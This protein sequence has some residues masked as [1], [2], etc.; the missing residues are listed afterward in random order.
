MA[1]TH[2]QGSSPVSTDRGE[3]LASTLWQR[4]DDSAPIAYQSVDGQWEPVPWAEL[5]SRVERLAAGLIASGV[6]KRDRVALMS[7]TRLEWTV[8]DLAVVSIGAVT[9]PIYPTDSE[10]QCAHVLEN[11]GARWAIAETGEHAARLESARRDASDLREVV[12]IDEGGLEALAQRGSDDD[13]VAVARRVDEL[14]PDD[15]ATI[16]YT[17]GTTGPPKGCALT[18]GN[19]N[20]TA[21]QAETALER[22]FAGDASTLLFLPLAHIFTRLIQFGCLHQ[23]V[24]VGY[25][26]SMDTLSEDVA[27]FQ[28]TFLLAVPRVFQKMHAGARRNAGGLQRRVFDFSFAHAQRYASV[29]EPGL[30]SK[31]VHAVV[32]RLVYQRIRQGLGGRAEWCVS[33]GAP[34][35]SELARWFTAAGITV[36]EGYGLTET[37]AVVAAD[38]PETV[39]IGTVGQPLPGVEVAISSEGEVLVRGPNVFQGYWSDDGPQD[40][41]ED[42]WYA[43]GD[44]GELSDDGHLT[45]TGRAKELVVTATGKNVAP[46]PLEERMKQH[47]LISQP[48]VVGDDRPFVGALITLDAEELAAFADEHGLDGEA[49]SLR[50]HERVR[51]EVQ[52]AVDDANAG[53]SQAESIRD[54]VILDREFAQDRGELTPTMKPRRNDIADHFADEIERLYQRE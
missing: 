39:R 3:H 22:M 26:R 17:S 53:V 31:A 18:H 47:R 51:K 24:A 49:D 52:Q 32:D 42:G 10:D 46:E 45:L 21:R 16:V 48:M 14:T 33:G 19:L 6:A 23:G 11:S 25:A 2:A 9:V 27:S 54:F 34:L 43:T 1:R 50:D 15:L 29:D 30:A 36:L 13:R 44:L 4:R 7:N 35:D 38:T 5:A 12:A 28:P 41:T 8:A 40:A 20:W 37:S